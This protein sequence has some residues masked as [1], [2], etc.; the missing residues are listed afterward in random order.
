MAL[1]AIENIQYYSE[2]ERIASDAGLDMEP[3]GDRIEPG[4]P[5][6]AGDAVVGQGIE[7]MIFRFA[8]RRVQL[9]P[10]PDSAAP[11][12]ELFTGADAAW[13]LGARRDPHDLPCS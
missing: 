13:P 1:E 3:P 12:L 5:A 9:G 4:V 8:S 10:E 2:V 6:A 7:G 11:C